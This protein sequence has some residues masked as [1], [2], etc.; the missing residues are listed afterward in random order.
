M[1]HPAV[2]QLHDDVHLVFL[3]DGQN[4]LKA[5]RTILQPGLVI[6]PGAVAGKTDQV[7]QP[8]ISGFL[9]PLLVNLNQGVVMLKTVKRPANAA[10]A[11]LSVLKR[12]HREAD[13]GA[14]EFVLP[15][16]REIRRIEQ[17]DR[18]HAKTGS[19]GR[20]FL[21]AGASI[22]PLADLYNSLLS[23]GK[24]LSLTIIP[25]ML[26]DAALLINDPMFLGSETSSKQAKVKFFL[27]K[28]KFFNKGV[29]KC[30]TSAT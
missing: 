30:S 21:K 5:D 26:K 2:E 16:R 9:D 19:L 13:H 4:P 7:F 27:F 29:S 18:L 11:G 23:L 6:H 3:R 28:I 10:D 17:L 1:V 25:L 15:H 8:G 12:A 22:A 24:C 20:Q 14:N